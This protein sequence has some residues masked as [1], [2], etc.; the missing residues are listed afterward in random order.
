ML[1]TEGIPLGVVTAID[2]VTRGTVEVDGIAGHAGT[3]PMPM[4]KRCAR[5]SGRNAAR[6]RGSRARS[7]LNLVATVGKLEVPG[8][9]PNT[10]PGRVRFTLDIRSPSDPERIKAV[11]DIKEGDR[12]DRRSAAA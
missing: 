6:R 12:R 5:G 2:G 4:R 11:D 3:V 1:E 7:Q 9:A 8:S 10:I